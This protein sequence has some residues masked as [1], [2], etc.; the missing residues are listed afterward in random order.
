MSIDPGAVTA[1]LF[2]VR[3]RRAVVT[4]AASGLGFAVAEVLADCGARVT[5][6]DVDAELLE[7]LAGELGA[8]GAR[9]APRSL[10]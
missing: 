9:F 8:R 2:D 5:L 7:A 1:R 4:G 3:E 10:T 6:A